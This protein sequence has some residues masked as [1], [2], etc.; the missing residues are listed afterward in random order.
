MVDFLRNISVTC[1]CTSYVVVLTLEILRLFG[2]IP[3]RAMMSMVMMGLGLFT[4]VTYL[5]LRA[6]GGDGQS[7]LLATWSDWSLLVSLGLAICFFIIYLQR[8]ETVVGFFF[9]PVVLAMIAVAMAVQSRPPFSRP[10]AVEIWRSVHALAMMAGTGIVLL[11][12]LAGVMFL[13]QSWR[14]KNHRAGSR[15]KLPTLETLSRWNRWSLVL[16]T[17]AVGVGLIA[18][19][20]MNLNQ[21]GYVGW[22]DRGVLLSTALFV[23]L[24]VATAIEYF[25]VPVRQS[26]KAVYLTLASAGFLAL[27]M[28][29]VMTTPHGKKE[30]P[31]DSAATA[32]LGTESSFVIAGPA[33]KRVV[34]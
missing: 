8:P 11:G 9:L 26:Y 19:V 27:A 10:Q 18:G 28:Y 5:W 14:L 22:T 4:H 21:W 32:F 24:V 20:V 30:S 16:G 13:A 29:G 23:W 31:S 2:R 6:G 17:L 15:L 33:M 3:G 1:F 34:G 25:Y 7:G 12:F